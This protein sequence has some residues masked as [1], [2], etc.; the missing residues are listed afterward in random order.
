MGADRDHTGVAKSYVEL[1]SKMKDYARNRKLDSTAKEGEGAAR[2][3]PR[4]RWSGWS[5]WEDVGGEHDF[6]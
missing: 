2:R 1:L 6:D 5:W 4:G 3:R